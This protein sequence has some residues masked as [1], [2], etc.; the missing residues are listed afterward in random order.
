MRRVFEGKRGLIIGDGFLGK[1][2]G[3]HLAEL[4]MSWEK[5]GRMSLDSLRRK[6]SDF[7]PDIMPLLISNKDRGE[8]ALSIMKVSVGEFGIPISTAEKAGFAYQ[9]EKIRLIPNWEKKILCNASVGGGLRILETL[10]ERLSYGPEFELIAVL[11]ASL[12]WIFGEITKGRDFDSVIAEAKLMKI[13]E[14]SKLSDYEILL[15]EFEDVLRKLCITWNIPLRKYGKPVNPD[16]FRR[17]S[18]NVEHLRETLFDKNPW[19]VVAVIRPIN[20]PKVFNRKVFAE[21]SVGNYVLSVELRRVSTTLFKS[22]GNDG[23]GMGPS[24]IN[25]GFLL[26]LDPFG[27]KYPIYNE[28]PGAGE[29]PTLLGGLIP[30]M[31]KLLFS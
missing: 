16:M 14:P 2:S 19:K 6:I 30:D 22:R 5:V 7:R 25:C 17:D 24:G 23:S 11:N 28:F 31:H 29:E 26:F 20:K 8:E 27:M 21:H 15:L 13:L 4:G 12:N 3:E 10:S 18:F 9:S 1:R